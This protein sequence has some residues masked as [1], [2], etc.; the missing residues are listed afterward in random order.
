MGFAFQTCRGYI[1]VALA[2]A[3]IGLGGITELMAAPR[4]GAEPAKPAEQGYLLPYLVTGI[5]I[6]LGVA[7]VCFPSQRKNEVE[8][9]EEE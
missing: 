4:K 6:C 9:E 3:V 1:A 2:L 7:A 5:A 8:I